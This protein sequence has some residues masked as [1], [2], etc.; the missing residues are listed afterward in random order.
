M[1]HCGK[2][3]P[4][5]TCEYSIVPVASSLDANE[6]CVCYAKVFLQITS[7]AFY[8]WYGTLCEKCFSHCLDS[9]DTLLCV[10]CGLNSN[11]GH[12]V[13]SSQNSSFGWMFFC[14]M[15]AFVFFNH[16]N[17]KGFFFFNL[18]AHKGAI[19]PL[20]VKLVF[21]KKTFLYWQKINKYIYNTI[22]KNSLSYCHIEVLSFP[23]TTRGSPQH[24]ENH[25][26]RLY[27]VIMLHFP[28]YSTSKHM[29]T[30]GK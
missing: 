15:Q 9:C 2:Q 6:A 5:L 27:L 14:S 8:L 12:V 30:I 26:L 16:H 18:R 3:T 23:N 13:F 17:R 10:R 22:F 4:W 1:L 24:F 25:C 7:H 20:Y 28:I 11:A 21:E 19:Q 29:I